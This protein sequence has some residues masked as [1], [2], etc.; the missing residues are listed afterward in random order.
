[1]VAVLSKVT[2]N[3]WHVGSKKHKMVITAYGNW[4][5][6]AQSKG[7][8]LSS[9]KPRC[10][11]TEVAPVWLSQVLVRHAKASVPTFTQSF[12]FAAKDLG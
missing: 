10:N 1:M 7:T 9:E 2:D 5:K 4:F 6:A 12:K 3:T 8:I 11:Q